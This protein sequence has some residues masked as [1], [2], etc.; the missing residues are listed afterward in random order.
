MPNG[1]V[2]VDGAANPAHQVRGNSNCLPNA[3][4]CMGQN[5]KSL[6]ACVCVCVC[7]RART[8]FGGPISRKRLEI[9]VWLQWG[10]NRK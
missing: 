10:T 6:A 8:G 2:V 1:G 4:Y 7:V 3:I 9:E 5:I